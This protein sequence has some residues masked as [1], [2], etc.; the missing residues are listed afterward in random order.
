MP[1]TINSA[2]GVNKSQPVIQR[3]PQKTQQTT[4]A[5]KNSPIT[6]PKANPTKSAP[7]TST[8]TGKGGRVNIVA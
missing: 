8:S 3:S 5:Q 7:K 2:Q 1:K 4:S 6:R